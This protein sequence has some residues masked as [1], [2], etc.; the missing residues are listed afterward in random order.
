MK[1]IAIHESSHGL[2]GVANN[3]KNAIEFLIKEEWLENRTMVYDCDSD[4]WDS[5]QNLWGANWKEIFENW[6]I[7][8]FNKVFE[9]TIRFE[10]IEVFEGEN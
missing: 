4:D 2:I 5:L 1:V 7:D 3:Y 6:D 9:G 10:E 8:F